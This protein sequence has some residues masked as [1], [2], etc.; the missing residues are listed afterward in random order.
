[1]NRRKRLISTTFPISGTFSQKIR[2][3]IKN[4]GASSWFYGIYRTKEIRTCLTDKSFIGVEFVTSFNLLKI[5][6]FYELDEIL[7]HRFNSG[8]STYGLIKIAKISHGMIFR[9]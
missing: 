1:M 2:K 7:F 4:P 9:K 5:G 8:W 3:Y 6:D